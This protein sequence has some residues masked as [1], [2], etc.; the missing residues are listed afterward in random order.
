[1]QLIPTAQSINFEKDTDYKGQYIIQPLYPGYGITLGNALRRVLLSSMPGAAVVSVKIDGV[2]HE[3]S[4]LEYVKEDVV[5]ILLNIKQLNLSVEGKLPDDEPLKISLNKTGEGKVTAKDFNCPTQ[6]KIANPDLHIATLTDKAA[7][8]NMEC[9]I[10]QGMG[11]WPTEGRDE[12]LDIGHI[13]VDAIFTP[14]NKVNVETEHVRVGE[15]TNWDKLI[16][17]IETNGTITCQQAFEQA[18]NILRQQFDALISGGEAVKEIAD[19]TVAEADTQSEKIV[20]EETSAENA[21]REESENKKDEEDQ[22]AA[23]EEKKKRGRPKK[24]D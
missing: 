5:D 15:M 7:K 18:V 10:G 9:Y 17:S 21:D 8:L 3:F 6:V 13:A 1:M 23:K 24:E 14:I 20:E 16:L 22:P 12:K 19:K 2:D 11:Y 4:S